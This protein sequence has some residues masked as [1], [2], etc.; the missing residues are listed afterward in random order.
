MNRYEPAGEIPIGSFGVSRNRLTQAC[1][2]RRSG[3]RCLTRAPAGACCAAAAAVR[4]GHLPK[5]MRPRRTGRAN[6]AH[7]VWGGSVTRHS[8]ADPQP[9]SW[10]QAVD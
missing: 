3:A 9:G 1:G 7:P 5:P 10:G 8:V 6:F 4:R 2:W